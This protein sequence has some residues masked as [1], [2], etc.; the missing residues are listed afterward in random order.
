MS[1]TSPEASAPAAEMDPF[2]EELIMQ[3]A[4]ETGY[5]PDQIRADIAR[6][7]ASTK[8]QLYPQYYSGQGIQ[9]QSPAAAEAPP[10]TVGQGVV[11]SQPQADPNAPPPMAPPE[12][13]AGESL[14]S[15][16]AGA[17]EGGI[18]PAVAQAM[19]EAM[20]PAPK[21]KKTQK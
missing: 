15:A 1:P 13:G 16:P 6:T 7:G 5:S 14:P 19:H 12:A 2:P 11:Q 17:P 21:Y 4:Q 9:P 18:D 8:E 3:I 10:A 20:R